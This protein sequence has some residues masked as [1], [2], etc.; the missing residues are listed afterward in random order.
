MDSNDDLIG[1]SQAAQILGVHRSTLSRW[2]QSGRITPV[3]QL[4]GRNGVVLYRRIDVEALSAD[5]V[6]AAG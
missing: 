6:Q 5:T 3:V 2:T 1:G 4:P